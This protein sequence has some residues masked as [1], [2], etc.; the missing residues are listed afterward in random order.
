MGKACCSVAHATDSSSSAWQEQPCPVVTWIN[1]LLQVAISLSVSDSYLFGEPIRVA[2]PSWISQIMHVKCMRALLSVQSLALIEN[3]FPGQ[4]LCI[5]WLQE[6]FICFLV[7]IS[8]YQLC[9]SRWSSFF[10]LT[11]PVA[12]THTWA[13][14]CAGHMMLKAS[15]LRW[16]GCVCLVPE[17]LKSLIQIRK[18]QKTC[19]RWGP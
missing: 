14:T 17:E 8:V 1:I 3:Q 15:A 7:S 18:S 5:T 6:D 4:P 16:S 19:G 10:F 12:C 11:W 2:M 9:F 13:S